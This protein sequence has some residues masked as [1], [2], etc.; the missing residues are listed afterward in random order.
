MLRP[1]SAFWREGTDGWG[2]CFQ[3]GAVIE[4]R[5]DWM[6]NSLVTESV[7]RRVIFPAWLELNWLSLNIEIKLEE[8]A[9]ARL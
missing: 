5:Q 7:A 1:G 6:G 9:A 8:A 4:C 2:P 3:L